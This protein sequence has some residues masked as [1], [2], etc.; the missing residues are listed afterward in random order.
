MVPSPM[1]SFDFLF[2]F[3]HLKFQ[4]NIVRD[5]HITYDLPHIVFTR[6]DSLAILLLYTLVLLPRKM[7]YMT[8]TIMELMRK[9]NRIKLYDDTRVGYWNWFVFAWQP[10]VKN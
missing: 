1:R 10:S 6:F 9:N 7:R 4:L 5:T 2:Y 3:F 8:N